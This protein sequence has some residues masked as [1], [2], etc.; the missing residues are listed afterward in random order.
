MATPGGNRRAAD[1][2]RR[3]AEF[4]AFVAG[5]GGRLLHSAVLLTGDPAEADRLLTAALARLYA[6]W[7]GLEGDDPYD[8]ARAELFVRYA[9]RPWRRPRGGPLDGL[10]ARQR[11]VVTMRYFEGIGEE[12]T[13]AVLGMACERVAAIAALGGA[14]LRSGP[15]RA[16]A[17][18]RTAAR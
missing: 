4:A 2:A 10:T 14:R 7:P 8:R 1:E 6:D 12:Q 9:Y 15:G 17:A 18:A 13:A 3:D 5:A 16:T 11:L